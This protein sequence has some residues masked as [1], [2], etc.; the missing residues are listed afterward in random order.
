[1]SIGDGEDEDPDRTGYEV[2]YGRPPRETQF[3]PGRSG[4]PAGR[5][6]ARWDLS[7][8]VGEV[9]GQ[10]VTVQGKNGAVEM[11]LAQVILETNSRKAAKGDLGAAKFVLSLLPRSQ[12]FG[13]R[14][15]SPE[16]EVDQMIKE[17]TPE[18]GRQAGEIREQLAT[19]L[20][21]NDEILE[22]DPGDDGLSPQVDTE[23]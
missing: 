12:P 19:Y 9:L 18:E 6:K 4:N 17:L 5:P 3:K 13:E 16:Q 1:M 2:G 10:N 11:P 15:L 8:L 14:T 23:S 20:P 22:F 21:D 7:M